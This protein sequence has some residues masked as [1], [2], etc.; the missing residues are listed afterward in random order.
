MQPQ[1]VQRTQTDILSADVKGYSRLMA[2]DE[3]AT[4]RTLTTYREVMAGLVQQHQGRV[5]D[6]PGDNVMAEFASVVDAVQCAVEIQRELKARN[7]D[8]AEN[9]KMELRIG[10]NLGDVIV[11]DERIY[12][13]GVNI[14]ARVEGLADGGGISISG[15][16]YDQIKNKLE[17]SYEFLGEQSVKNIAE[18]VRVYRAHWD[19][20]AEVPF[21]VEDKKAESEKA[22][23]RG[24]GIG[25]AGAVAAGL[26]VAAGW[27]FLSTQSGQRMPALQHSAMTT[28]SMHALDASKAS[29]QAAMVS[30]AAPAHS[31]RP[32][33][34]S[35]GLIAQREGDP[36]QIVVKEGDTLR[37]GDRFRVKYETSDVAYVYVLVLDS[38]GETTQL[39]PDPKIHASNKASGGQKYQ[40]PTG[41]LWLGLDEIPGVETVFV[42]ASREPLPNVKDLVASLNEVNSEYLSEHRLARQLIAQA[43]PR[44]GVSGLVQGESNPTQLA[45]T[46]LIRRVTEAIQKEVSAVRAVSFLHQ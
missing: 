23:P 10:I 5:V 30:P 19:P 39:F 29:G 45:D 12:G 34:I 13:D 4:V 27:Y 32:L 1:N 14:A 42:L 18:P 38:Q 28:K 25:V 20:D 7:A 43:Q 41:S 26:L 22:R 31:V 6:S 11:D 37:S 2:D 9:R 16:V 15:T 3:V 17:L 33:E 44:R 46:K 36:A 24:L 21:P 40:V 35:M 8:L